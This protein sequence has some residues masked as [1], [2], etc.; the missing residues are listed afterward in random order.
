[1]IGRLP[2]ETSAL[3][4]IW[5]VPELSARGWRGALMTPPAVAEIQ[6]LRRNPATD[7]PTKPSTEE[8]AAA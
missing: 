7:Q 5:A 4:L 6:R 2:G 1:V 3:S 8:A